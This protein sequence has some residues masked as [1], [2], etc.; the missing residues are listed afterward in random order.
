MLIDMA[1]AFKDGDTRLAEDVILREREIDRL[2][3]LVVRQ[4]KSAVRYQQVS[5]KLGITHQRDSLGYR[6]VVKS[7][8]RIA[9][10]I[11]NIAKSYIRLV[12]IEKEPNL[13]KFLELTISVLGIY[14]KAATAMF[15]QDAVMVDEVFNKLKE[16]EECHLK[17]SNQVFRQKIEVQS[18]LLQ[19]T[20]LDSISRIAGY[21]ADI[22]EIAINMSVKV[23]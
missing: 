5:E 23:P 11:E 2:Y 17:V 21:S 14:E 6:I 12:E 22:A 7:F 16:I 19:K 4:L 10:H 9:D 3:F 15:K 20:M 1:K 18:S 13:K 8:E